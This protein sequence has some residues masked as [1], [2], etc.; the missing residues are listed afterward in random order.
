LRSASDAPDILE[1]L[2]A[3][4]SQLQVYINNG[5]LY[6]NSPV[7]EYISIYSIK[8]TELYRTA[9]AVP[10]NTTT[11]IVNTGNLSVSG[12]GAIIKGS[13][14]WVKKLLIVYN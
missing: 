2:I 9:T 7:D 10:A 12:S 14:G 5:W 3:I 6:V 13:S 1:D 8:G 11:G 4:L